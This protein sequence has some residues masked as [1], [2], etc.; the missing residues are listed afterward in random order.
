MLKTVKKLHQP[1]Q[2]KV[3]QK[4]LIRSAQHT[5]TKMSSLFNI[6]PYPESG[7]PPKI[8]LRLHQLED[9]E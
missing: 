9:Y 4:E 8:D 1:T 5:E 7:K 6:D 2:L 3:A